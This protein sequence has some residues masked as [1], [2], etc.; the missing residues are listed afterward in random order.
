M[1]ESFWNSITIK[2]TNQGNLKVERWALSSFG[3]GILLKLLWLH[4]NL[5]TNHGNQSWTT[6]YH[7][8]ILSICWHMH[9]E[10]N[11]HQIY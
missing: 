6:A 9:I 2:N 1:F 4:T 11:A 7:K 8:E 5:L 10:L 3:A